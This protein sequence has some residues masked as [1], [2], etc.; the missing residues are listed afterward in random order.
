MNQQGPQFD[1]SPLIPAERQFPLEALLVQA[2]YGIGL[3]ECADHRWSYVNNYFVRMTGRRSEADFLGKT[4]QESLPETGK[5]GF[6]EVIEQAC[7]SGETCRVLEMKLSLDSITPAQPREG[8]FDFVFQP[9]RNEEGQ[10]SALVVHALDVTSNVK[11]RQALEENAQRLRLAQTAAQIGTWEWD[12]VEDTRT[13]SPE[14]YRMFG[15]SP[16]DPDSTKKW[17]ERVFAE[18]MPAVSRQMLQGHRR[19]TMDFEYRYQHPEKGPRWFYCKGR[20]V[21]GETRMYGIVLDVTARK[22]T[23]DASHRLAAIVESS[24][25]AISSKD[26]NGIVTSWNGAAERIFGYSAA[27]MIGKSILTII[28]PELHDDEAKILA[29]IA[30]G[31]RIEHFETVR[32][33]KSGE[34]IDVSL[35]IS[36]VRN[37]SGKIIGAAKI[38]RNITQQKKA[39]RALRISERLASVGRLAAT[40][41]HEI[42]NPLEAIT[43]LIFLAKSAESRA[44]TIKFLTMAEDELARV[45]HLTRQTLGF[46]RE[47][48]PAAGVPAGEL[49]ESLAS[50]FSSRARNRGVRVR[51]EVSEGA[52]ATLVPAEIRQVLANLVSNSMDAMGTGGQMRIRASESRRWKGDGEHGV[53]LTIADSGSGIPKAIRSKLFDPFFTT[54]KD[55]GTGLGLWVSK[56]IVENNR[57]EIRVK[58]CA[59]PGRSWTAFSVFMPSSAGS[60]AARELFSR[61]AGEALRRT[62]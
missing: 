6:V 5:Q 2:P 10:I 41:A 25:D 1:Q 12:P 60:A 59:E 26:L 11:V 43:N 15:T 54:K 46:Y 24:D 34:R 40:V 49:I 53:R 4:V 62:A 13:L 35:T 7:A 21:R 38:A 48:K 51:T 47:S 31:E 61:N 50:V 22:A 44:D 55:V 33:T 8:Y 3:M 20:R 17:M 45:S 14:L 42:N 39:E 37:E 58:S 57:G 28:P 27:E 56:E 52:A 23:E 29:T 18:D 36:P 30:R 9:L 16:S 32:V 19:G